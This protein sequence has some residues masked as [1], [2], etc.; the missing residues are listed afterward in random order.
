MFPQPT[1]G[2]SIVFAF[3]LLGGL[4]AGEARGVVV[5]PEEQAAAREW[6][7]A[8]FEGSVPAGPCQPGLLVLANHDPFLDQDTGPTAAPPFSFVYD[9]RS[10]AVLLAEWAVKRERRVLDDQ[11]TEHTLTY[12][13]SK[14]G[15][16]VRAVGVEYHDFPTVEWTLYFRNTG[17]VDTPL[18]TDIRAID[19]WF[20]RGKEGEF[21][22][23]HN[24]GSPAGP[25]DYEPHA[26]PLRPKATVR[27]ATSGGR[28]TNSD[29]PYFNIAWP[30]QGV[31]V[32]LGWPGQWAA[33]F[34]RDERQALRVHGG[35]ERTRFKLHPGEEVR[36]PLAVVQ[37]WKGDVVRSQNIWRR[38]ML[39][40]NSPRPGGKPMPTG[41]MMC[42]SDSYPGMRSTAVGE[43]QYVDAYAS[44]GIKLDYWWIDAGWYPCEP[45]GWTHIGTWEPDPI[46]YPK[47]LKEVADY[48]H[49]KGM[50]FVVWFEPERVH[51]GS[52]LTENHPEWVLGG[53]EGGLLNHGDR[54]ARTWLT[55]HV[56][57]MLT[58]HGIDLYRQDFNMDPLSY[59]RGHDAPDRQGI[60]EIGHVE[61]YLAYWDE[62][63]RRHPNM[64][65]DT[66]ASGGRRN[67]LETLRRAVPLLRS[68]YR[69]EP[70]GT[71][72]HTFGMAQWI[73]YFGTGVPDTND[74]VVRSH[75]CPWLGI[76]RD[77]P[78]R[79]G[80]DW[81]DYHRM[82][83]QWR[84]VCDYMLG[85]YYPLTSYSL[86][87]TAWIAWQ[88]DQPERG[89]GMVQVFRR[90]ESPYES[91]RF[92]LCG[93]EADAQYTLTDLDSGR[94]EQRTGRRLMQEGLPVDI[95]QR[96][97]AV[98][99]LYQKS[100]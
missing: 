57:R 40:H 21:T 86:D 11:R 26:T 27:I 29:M 28:S 89:E 6:V 81:T 96:P 88:F 65:I 39:A 43:K 7:A 67:D 54:D 47:G 4:A 16:V 79:E 99:I 78:Q 94:K 45:E 69:F 9:G 82:V 56:D 71:Q 93:L 85:D 49:G 72:G 84:R 73:P 70:A 13:D 5:T 100:R 15:L 87:N 97:R 63:R 35:Q 52:W 98:V 38:W 30:G 1:Q 32:V 55:E 19:T 37:F 41:L 59:W 46:R 42:T 12:T 8:K 2:Q 80:L 83:A 20:R 74:Y 33:E 50:K 95:P 64:P 31:I 91:A 25:N 10:S 58:E 92:A 62:L 48:V 60:T 76:G 44:A 68:D 36:S 75:W 77:R 23:H 3:I 18:L 53:K 90:G 17:A 66:C 22:L 61:G 34:S 51:A 14:T 24:T